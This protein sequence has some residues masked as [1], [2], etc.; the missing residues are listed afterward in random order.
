LIDEFNVKTIAKIVGKVDLKCVMHTVEIQ[1]FT[2]GE[3]LGV[4]E[5]F[6]E[7]ESSRIAINNPV[8]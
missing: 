8:W 1:V 3:H 2:W 6:N 4:L 7:Y 5:K